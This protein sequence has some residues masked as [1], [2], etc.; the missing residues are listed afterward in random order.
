MKENREFLS[1][2]G[3]ELF[4]FLIDDSVKRKSHEGILT[5][6]TIGEIIRERTIGNPFLAYM[7]F[8]SSQEK[9]TQICLDKSINRHIS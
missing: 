4:P 7:V 5:E 8:F 3:E 2:E 6:E 1:L 9:E